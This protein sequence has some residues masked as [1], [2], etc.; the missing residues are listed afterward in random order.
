[1]AILVWLSKFI[2]NLSAVP[3]PATFP[4]FASGLGALGLVGWR[5]KRKA[6]AVA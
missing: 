4:L 6:Q 2:L 1:M 3:L 5:R